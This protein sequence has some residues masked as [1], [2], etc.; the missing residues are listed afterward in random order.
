MGG[1]QHRIAP[2]PQSLWTLHLI[3]PAIWGW[4][5]NCPPSQSCSGPW[6]LIC[7][8]YT[9][10]LK[11]FHHSLE[12]QEPSSPRL[13]WIVR[14]EKDIE[15]EIW[16]AIWIYKATKAIDH[17]MMEMQHDHLCATQMCVII[18]KNK[19]TVTMMQVGAGCQVETRWLVSTWI[20]S[21]TAF[22]LK[23]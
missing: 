1:V 13:S 12:P 9:S 23:H 2:P 16:A 20:W 21:Q 7:L 5:Y 6:L 10:I 15:K 19:D 18:S 14:V 11:G 8:Y 4:A 22:L 3:K 17:V